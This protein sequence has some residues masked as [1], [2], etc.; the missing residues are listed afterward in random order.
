MS[1]VIEKCKNKIKK[2]GIITAH[3]SIPVM[4]F[5]N[6]AVEMENASCTTTIYSH[7]VRLM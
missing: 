6:K 4:A 2:I 7:G 5:P 1:I 3:Y